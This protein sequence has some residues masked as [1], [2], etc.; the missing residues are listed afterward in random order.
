MY[1]IARSCRY[2]GNLARPGGLPQSREGH[3]TGLRLNPSS[4]LRVRSD[5]LCSLSFCSFKLCE[6]IIDNQFLH[7][8]NQIIG[9]T[10]KRN[11]L[12]RQKKTLKKTMQISFRFYLKLY[13]HHKTNKQTKKYLRVPSESLNSARSRVSGVQTPP[14]GSPPPKPYL[15]SLKHARG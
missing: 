6:M 11:V 4:L 3:V 2:W 8:I 9:E 10:Q 1:H 7:Q 13:F 15:K 14:T 12:E 5:Q